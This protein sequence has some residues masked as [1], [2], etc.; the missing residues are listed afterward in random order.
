[1][2]ENCETGKIDDNGVMTRCSDHVKI[3]RYIAA[4]NESDYPD[5]YGRNVHIPEQFQKRIKSKVITQT[6]IIIYNA[7]FCR[8]EVLLDNTVYKKTILLYT[9]G[10][11]E[12]EMFLVI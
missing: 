1:M 4:C 5:Q 12:Y 10:K 7:D 3:S 2:F 8:F 9:C 6:G 11:D